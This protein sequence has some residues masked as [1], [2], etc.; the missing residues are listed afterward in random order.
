M[1]PLGKKKRNEVISLRLTE[2]RLEVLER[3]RKILAQQLHRPVSISE[4]AFLVFEERAPE[5]DRDASRYEM[6]T[7][8]TQSLWQ[9]RKKWESRHT[10]SAPEWDVLAEYVQIGAE[11]KTQE[12][13]L[14]RPAVPSRESQLALLDAFEAV[15]INRKNHASQHSWYYFSNLGGSSTE[16]LLSRDDPDKRHNVV[17]KE[18]ESSR[19]LLQPQEGWKKPGS[20]GACFLAAVRD[21]GVESTRL[22]EVLA[23]YWTTLWG[24]AARGHWIRHD[25][26]PVRSRLRNANE[27]DSRRGIPLPGPI[28]R[29]D[30]KISFLRGDTEFAMQIDFRGPRPLTYVISEYPEMVEFNVMLESFQPEESW[31]GRFFFTFT[32]E[33]EAPYTLC[34]NRSRLHVSFSESE[35]RGLSEIARE[36][37]RRPQL[38]PW[39]NELRLEYGE[40]G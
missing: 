32:S 12:P 14:M 28:H 26:Q 33:A 8:P 21:E 35:W 13:P 30:L 7:N 24:L 39:L 6:L 16:T 36:A 23:P 5:V 38:Q 1:S 2:D 37:W 3:Y 29:D 17:L 34:L 11:E 22:D 15:Y 40:Q 27:S 31:H 19:K 25:G 18:I 10:L 4:A 9:I 20:I